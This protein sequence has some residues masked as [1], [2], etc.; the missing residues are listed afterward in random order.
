MKT[1]AFTLLATLVLS[2]P[3]YAEDSVA[4]HVR[5]AIDKTKE[6]VEEIAGS[7]QN[8]SRAWFNEA[9]ENLRL[10]R[11]EYTERAERALARFD[12]DITVLK[13]LSGGPGQRDYFKTRVFALQ[14]HATF[15]RTELDT[16]RASESEEVFRARQKSF[17][18]TLWTLESAVGEAQEE[19]GI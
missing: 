8:H 11:P 17:D 16:L 14:Q 12:A 13:E 3:L 6:K 4:D 15:A 18:R 5:R 10:T 19:A 9:R 1:I 7:V 2:A